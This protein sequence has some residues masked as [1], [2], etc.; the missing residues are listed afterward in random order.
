MDTGTAL[1]RKAGRYATIALVL[2]LLTSPVA[3]FIAGYISFFGPVTTYIAS[4]I[5]MFLLIILTDWSTKAIFGV[6]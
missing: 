6:D 3:G 5:S 2:L 4:F 1:K